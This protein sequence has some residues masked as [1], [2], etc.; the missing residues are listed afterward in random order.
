MEAQLPP[1]YKTGNKAF[2]QAL[3]ARGTLTFEE[4]R[5]IISAIWNADTEGN[6][7]AA[8]QTLDDVDEA[9]FIRYMD[10]AREAV[11]LFDYDIRTTI[12]Q[13]SKQR[14]YALINT[15]SDP[16]TQ[17][18][19]TYAPDELSYIKRLFDAM[20]ETNNTPR[21]E[22]MAIQHMQAVKCARPPN[23]RQSQMNGDAEDEDSTQQ[24]ADRGLKHSEVEDV[25][26]SLCAGGWMERSRAKYFSLAP[27]G[28]LE[29]RPWL[30]ETYN[31]PDAGPDG[32]QRIKKCVACKDL[33]TYGLRCAEPDCTFR[34]HDVCETAYWASRAGGQK[35]QKCSREWTGKNYVGERAA[36]HTDA[37]QRRKNT[38]VGGGS[39]TSTLA[40]EVA[41]QRRRQQEEEDENEDV[42]TEEE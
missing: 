3:M 11:S 32:W 28:L 24:P 42:D 15:T 6:E 23:R 27:R 10:M 39:R 25:L 34:L 31:D 9:I 33:I 35:C 12:H 19:T 1:N 38:S 14:I 40:D 37:A 21:M 30:L 41:T 17:L 8:Q 29:L 20:F 7:E 5:P 13:I 26:T 4:A 36:T 16:Q 22:I 18:A 2:L